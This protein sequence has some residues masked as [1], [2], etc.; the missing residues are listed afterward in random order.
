MNICKF[1]KIMI[2]D[3]IYEVLSKCNRE[4]CFVSINLWNMEFP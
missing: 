4:Y 1:L 3:E 2:I